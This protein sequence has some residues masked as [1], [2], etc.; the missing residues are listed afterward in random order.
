MADAPAEAPFAMHGAREVLAAGAGH[1]E[2]QIVAIEEAVE[3]NPGLAF[4]LAKTLVESMCK[5]VLSECG[6]GYDEA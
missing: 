2:Q 4:D 6:D 3:K 1:I 5:T